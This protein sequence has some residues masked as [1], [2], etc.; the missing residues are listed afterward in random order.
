VLS[1]LSVLIGWVSSF[2]ETVYVEH[3]LAAGIPIWID[4]P[5]DPDTPPGQHVHAPIGCVDL[6]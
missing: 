5:D 4:Q 3:G 2:L 1:Q 6:R